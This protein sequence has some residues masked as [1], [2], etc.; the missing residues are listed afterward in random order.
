M[1]KRLLEGMPFTEWVAEK[2]DPPVPHCPG[3]AITIAC[4]TTHPYSTAKDP[5]V[6]PM[7]KTFKTFFRLI[8]HGEYT[9]S[10]AERQA[11]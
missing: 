7:R 10:Q 1:E 5:N 2:V 11:D 6:W 3:N 4:A 9:R 8:F